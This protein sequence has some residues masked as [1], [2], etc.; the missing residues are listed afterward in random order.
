[1]RPYCALAASAFFFYSLDR[2]EPPHV[3][4]EHGDRTAKYWLAPVEPAS[5]SKFRNS[6]LNAVRTLVVEHAESF[7]RR[8]HEHFG[9]F[10]QI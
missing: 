1:M 6:E 8:W 9:S 7:Q 2:G 10:G 4:V 5:S 3:H